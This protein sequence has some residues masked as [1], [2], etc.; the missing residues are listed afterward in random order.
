[1]FNAANYQERPAK[2]TTKKLVALDFVSVCCFVPPR[3]GFSLSLFGNY[4][5]E[6]GTDVNATVTNTTV[7]TTK[8]PSGHVLLDPTRHELD[9]KKKH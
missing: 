5:Q 7:A 1:M 4:N 3:C 2:T 8:P 9:T 6:A